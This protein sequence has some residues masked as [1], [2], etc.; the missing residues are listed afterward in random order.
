[1]KLRR[2]LEDGA[3]WIKD[4]AKDDHVVG[5]RMDNECLGENLGEFSG[6]RVI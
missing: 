5:F 4:F 1:M 6:A 3:I 2:L